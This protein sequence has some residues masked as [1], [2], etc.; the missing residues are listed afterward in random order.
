MPL[1]GEA[2]AAFVKGF[3]LS[4]PSGKKN[5]FAA[6]TLPSAIVITLRDA[7]RSALWALSSVRCAP[8]TT[9]SLQR[10]LIVWL[11]TLPRCRRASAWSLCVSGWWGLLI[12]RRRWPASATCVPFQVVLD[13]VRE[14][15]TACVQQEKQ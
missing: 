9:A 5:S 3:A 6:D 2:A 10:R 14:A 7:V 12:C 13:E 8:R 4:L 15:V 11:S 1:T